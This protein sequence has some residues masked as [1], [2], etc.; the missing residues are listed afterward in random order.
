MSILDRKSTTTLLSS[1][2]DTDNFFEDDEDLFASLSSSPTSIASDNSPSSLDLSGA[3][4]RQ[5]NLGYDIQIASYAGALGFDEVIDWEYFDNPGEEKRNIVEPPP[6]DPTKPKRTRSSSGSVIRI[7]RGELLGT[8][9]GSLRSRGLEYRVLLKEYSGEM[10]EELASRELDTMGKL[11]SQLCAELNSNC[12][13]GDWAN[14]ASS[15]YLLGMDTGN[16]R[17]DDSSLTQLME[18]LTSPKTTRFSSSKALP[19]IGILGRLNLSEYEND[20]DLDPNEWYRA[21]G[22]PGPKP[23]SIWI[24]Y[25]YAG[26]STFSSYAQPPLLRRAKIPPKKGMFGNVVLP[27][28]LPPW[29]ERASYVLKLFEKSLE[30]LATLHENGIAHRSIGRS[31]L[32]LSTAEL[33]KS[34]PANIYTTNAMSTLVKFCDFGFAGVI[35]ESAKDESF[36]RRAKTFGIDIAEPKSDLTSAI[37]IQGTNFA[38]AEDLHAVGF[39]FLGILLTTLAEPKNEQ[40]QMPKTDEDSLQRL[41]GEIFNNDMNKF[42]EYCDEEEM[43]ENVVQLLDENEGAGWELLEKLC[44]ARDRVKEIGK[45]DGLQ[46]MTVRGLLS[47]TLFQ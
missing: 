32:V 18:C 8:M 19:L 35:S 17:K 27:P 5:F 37:S 12:K 34:I 11:Q 39:V 41:L 20:P 25:E 24:V 45:E 4:T 43:W 2:D 16:T 29:N 6:F 9:A 1:F 31:S 28:P 38:I 33:D 21:L 44:F 10:A 7:F 26:L 46:L 14:T 36:R 3:T 30:G 40:Y 42:R 15:R 47:N 22:V 23:N 13:Q